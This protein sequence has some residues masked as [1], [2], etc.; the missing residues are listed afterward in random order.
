MT[1]DAVNTGGCAEGHHR[2]R[3]LGYLRGPR[4]AWLD[5]ERP[6]QVVCRG[7]DYETRWRCDGHRESRCAPCA[8]RYRRRVRRVA[9]SG[10]RQARGGWQ[11]LLTLTAPGDS[12][13]VD[14]FGQPCPCTPVGGVNLS[15]WNASHSR[16]WNHFRTLLRRRYP[17]IEYF[18][19]IEVQTRGALHDHAMVWSPT[20]LR[21]P[22]VRRL[23]MNAGF[24]HSV[25]LAECALGSKRAA[26]Y[27]SKY[28]T[29]ATDMRAQVPWWGQS[30][31]CETGEVTEGL[32]DG[33]YRTWS[34]SRHWGLSMKA[35][36]AE[37]RAWLLA[38]QHAEDDAMIERVAAMFG[39][40][41]VLGVPP[42]SPSP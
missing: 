14:K 20:P 2:L 41:Q 13:H 5:C 32:M 33:R 19:G 21:R 8:A 7:C 10:T 29:K 11:Y 40:V 26:W 16:R 30:V 36:R 23:A 24:G 37:A 3:P 15:Q 17:G 4:P 35:V 28:V 27:T 42:P 1:R 31:D 38:R 12:E 39:D 22:E 6:L 25:D 9:E 18:R 34:M